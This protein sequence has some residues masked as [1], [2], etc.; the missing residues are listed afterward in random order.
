[1][2]V[3]VV[4]REVDPVTVAEVVVGEAVAV[5]KDSQG[6]MLVTPISHGAVNHHKVENQEASIS[7]NHLA[8]RYTLGVNE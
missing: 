2:V 4:G 8:G 5:V 7:P 1:M 6:V 3:V